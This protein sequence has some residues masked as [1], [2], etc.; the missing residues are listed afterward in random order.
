MDL[1]VFAI[2][3]VVAITTALLVVLQRN[4]MYSALYLIVTLFCLALLYLQLGA[5]FLSVSQVIVYAGAIM[6]LF[7][8]VIMLLNQDKPM[9]TEPTLRLQNPM[10]AIL[11]L[12]LFLELMA[13]ATI[14]VAP[15]PPANVA[16][17]S[18]GTVE[19]VAEALFTRYLFPFEL[20]SVMLLVGMVGVVV[21][22]KRKV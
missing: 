15:N 2:V 6:V 22:A 11:G 13:I 10:A 3:A 18:P 16:G 19:S 20:T 7:L 5:Q 4:P 8:F 14:A 21:L 9:D 12:L 17:A 1:L